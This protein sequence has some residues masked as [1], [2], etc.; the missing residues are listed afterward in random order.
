M[1]APAIASAAYRAPDTSTAEFY[2]SDIPLRELSQADSFDQLS[3][4]IV[5]LHLFIRP[6]PGKTP[7]E[8]T[9]SSATIQTVVLARGEV[10]LYGGGG[11]MLPRGT[12]GDATLGGSIRDGSVRLLASTPGFVDRLGATD[13]SVGVNAPRDESGAGVM[14]HVFAQ[15]LRL[16]RPEGAAPV[17]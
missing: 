9:A 1:L 15:A 2:L 17:E 4:T 14:A 3:G 12:P 16:A 10:G 13:F 8:P 11:F 7:I 5:H 6:K